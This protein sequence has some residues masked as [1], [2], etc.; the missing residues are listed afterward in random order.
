MKIIFFL[1]FF[2]FCFLRGLE[3]KA[4][5]PHGMSFSCIVEVRPVFRS[6]FFVH[7]TCSTSQ[8]GFFTHFYSFKNVQL[9]RRWNVIF[10]MSVF[11]EKKDF[12]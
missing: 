4:S 3:V 1:V 11:A 2:F 8:T 12:P 10:Q 7:W 5:P 6:F 9:K